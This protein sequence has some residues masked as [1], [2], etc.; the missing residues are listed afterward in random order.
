MSNETCKELINIKYKTMLLNPNSKGLEEDI[1]TKTTDTLDEFL[2]RK[3]MV[4]TNKSWSQLNKMN[5]VEKINAFVDNISLDNNLS[6]KDV[7]DLKKYLRTC[8]DRKMLQRMRDITYDKENEKITHI[9]GLIIK[10]GKLQ[11]KEKRFT[12]KMSDKKTGTQKNKPGKSKKQ[13][14]LS[15]SGINFS[16]KNVSKD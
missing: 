4:T 12:L 2:K 9:N 14:L 11:E 13:K 6:S 7:E 8:L 3:K 10:K 15:N 5:K 16:N 1:E